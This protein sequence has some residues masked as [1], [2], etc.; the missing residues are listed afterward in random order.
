MDFTF[1]SEQDDFRASTRAFL[2]KH[3]AGLRSR[4][5]GSFDRPLWTK[6]TE[7]LGLTALAIP[8]PAGGIGASLVE[9]A[10]A[11][12]ESGRVLLCVPYLSTVVAA[13]ALTPPLGA[14][15]SL[16]GDVAALLG[17]IAA[18]ETV[19]TLAVAEAGLRWGS[20]WFATTA[21]RRGDGY[22]IEGVKEHVLDGDVADLAVVVAVCDGELGLFAVRAEDVRRRGM[23]TVDQ[24][25]PVARWEFDNAPA[26]R[27]SGPGDEG[28]AAAY[29]VDILHAALAVEA[30]GTAAGSLEL[31]VAYL[32]TRE[33]F[34]VPLATFQALRH[35]VA[36]LA[37][38]LD[39]ATS[40]AWYAIR[41]AGAD[42]FGVCAPVA[43]LVA[44]DAAYAVAADSIQLHGGIGFTWEHDAHRYFKRATATRLTYGDPPALRRLIGARAAL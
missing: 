43:K 7:E 5:L 14:A 31:T 36:D 9:V 39:A 40:S 19:A 2:A 16:D 35:R 34:G 11:L 25:R 10:I 6:L 37:V 13:A 21:R 15:D 33:Q 26:T 3:A 44:A 30:V 18:G 28:A 4:A 42:E 12:E 38:S 27:I 17:G 41:T 1:S 24:T 20:D 32:K 23:S 8:E 29:A 22:V